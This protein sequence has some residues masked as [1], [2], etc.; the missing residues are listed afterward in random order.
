MSTGIPFEKI[1]PF[2]DAPPGLIITSSDRIARAVQAGYIE[3]ERLQG[4]HVS[5]PLPCFSY[6]QWLR[7][8]FDDWQSDQCDSHLLLDSS[9]TEFLLTQII[10]KD[11]DIALMNPSG[12]AK[13]VLAALKIINEWQID[14][15]SIQLSAGLEAS[16]L[17]AWLNLLKAQCEKYHWVPSYELA[18]QV[19]KALEN[20]Q[21]TLPQSILWVGFDEFPPILTKLKSKLSDFEVKQAEYYHQLE[22]NADIQLFQTTDTLSECQFVAQQVFQTW[23]AYPDAQIA[24]VLPDLEKRIDQIQH[25]FSLVFHPEIQ[26]TGSPLPEAIFNISAGLYLDHIAIV[27]ACLRLWS[28]R[29]DRLSVDDLEFLL[30]CPYSQILNNDEYFWTQT[31]AYWKHNGR[32]VIGINSIEKAMLQYQSDSNCELNHELLNIAKRRNAKKQALQDTVLGLVDEIELW[33]VLDCRDLDETEH[34]ALLNLFQVVDQVKQFQVAQAKW[35]RSEILA[36][37]HKLV[38]ETVYQKAASNRRIHILGTLEAAGLAFDHVFMMGMNDET[39]PASPSPNPFI[40]SSIQ[41]QYQVPRSTAERELEV[42]TS[43]TQ[44]LIKACSQLYISYSE[45]LDDKQVSLSPLFQPYLERLKYSKESKLPDSLSYQQAELLWALDE[46][47]PALKFDEPA[48]GGTSLLKSQAACPFQAF[49]KF[50]LKIKEQHREALGLSPRERGLLVHR[51]LELIWTQLKEQSALLALEQKA[52]KELI[53]QKTNQAITELCEQQV[54]ERSEPFWQLESDKLIQ[55]I[56]T[57]LQQERYRQPFEVESMELDCRAKVGSIEVKFQVDR[58]DRL[59]T[60][61]IALI[62]YKTSSNYKASN[63]G[64]MR[65]EEPQMLLYGTHLSPVSAIAYAQITPKKLGF[66]GLAATEKLLPDVKVM[67]PDNAIKWDLPLDWGDMLAK[68]KKVLHQLGEDFAQGQAKV[69]PKMKIKTCQ[70]CQYKGICRVN[71]EQNDA[72]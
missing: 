10:K 16:R 29:L 13:Q 4:K 42:A 64:G 51:V 43:I 61:D 40:P 30:I 38:S 25:Q 33:G 6:K 35:N 44:H 48:R 9:V 66:S 22:Q 71:E 15:E 5:V 47:A 12:T 63:W 49:A 7:N 24:V 70:Y 59:H 54:L 41:K 53:K 20:S 67:T 56:E 65:P 3:H 60:G 36:L 50:R 28:M 2:F 11:Q 37:L 72:V 69:E 46:N 39:W 31:I 68:W 32:E 19:L 57:W 26:Q 58:V 55:M 17:V 45:F 18:S 8:S 14:V 34:E 62:D 52:V 1:I 23:Q 27:S 21:L